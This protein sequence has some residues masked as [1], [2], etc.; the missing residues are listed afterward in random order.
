MPQERKFGDIFA[1]LS[2]IFPEFFHPHSKS[3]PFPPILIATKH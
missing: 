2:K 3:S 1:R